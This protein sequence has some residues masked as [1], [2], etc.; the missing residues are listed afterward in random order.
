MKPT[1]KTCDAISG[2][3]TTAKVESSKLNTARI[4]PVANRKS[5]AAARIAKTLNG[6]WRGEVVGD[7]GDV[8]VDY[9]WIID[10]KAN[11]ALIIAQRSGKETLDAPT[12]PANA[13]KLTYLMC[14]HD[15]YSPGSNTPQIHQF[16][17]VSTSTANAAEIVEKATGQKSVMAKPS[18]GDLWRG[19][20]SSGYFD[21]LPYVAYAGGYFKPIQ[22]ASVPSLTKGAAPQVSM[23]W[24]AEYRG[25]G[26]TKLK[27]TTGVPMTGS[28]QVQFVG[29]AATTGDYLVSSP[30][31]GN[32]WKVE[33]VA[34]GDYDLAFDQ[35][36]LGPLEQ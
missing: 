25:G 2:A 30:G 16:V 29:A 5:V 22:I 24:D 9:F 1:L 3:A 17:R 7:T 8:H 33:V 6:V 28:E 32:L 21:S 15:G 35:V 11:E 26:S 23:R 34:G 14:A 36:S 12:L 13:P 18:L 20:I 31:N 19:L 10:T 27:Y 4:L